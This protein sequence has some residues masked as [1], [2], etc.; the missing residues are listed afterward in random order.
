MALLF[1]HVQWWIPMPNQMDGAPPP[2]GTPNYLVNCGGGST[3]RIGN[4]FRGNESF[5]WEQSYGVAQL[6]HGQGEWW[7]AQGGAANNHRMMMIGWSRDLNHRFR[8]DQFTTRLTLLR[9]VNWDVKTQNLVSNPVPEL[10]GLRTGVLA[11]E[12]IPSL[13]PVDSPHIVAKTSGG[14]AA[15]AD[16]VVKFSGFSTST[17]GSFGACVLSNSTSRSGI[18]LTITIVPRGPWKKTKDPS[19]RGEGLRMAITSGVCQHA[20]VASSST[21]GRHGDSMDTHSNKLVPIFDDE[22]E[23]T[24]RILPDRAVADFFVQGGR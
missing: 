16:I 22:T 6:E 7:G 13:P 9:E 11:S 19:G 18:G 5:I 24:M 15:S 2:A 23:V 3:Y 10:L 8:T 21:G 4:Y 17:T 14:A 1:A 20:S 12:N